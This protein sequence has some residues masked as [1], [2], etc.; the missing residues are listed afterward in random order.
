MG[1]VRTLRVPLLKWILANLPLCL[2]PGVTLR[3]SKFSS[4]YIV[5]SGFTPEN[6]WDLT[7]TDKRVF[8]CFIL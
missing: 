5:P 3:S 6:E 2:E 4:S 7:L 8:F 1:G